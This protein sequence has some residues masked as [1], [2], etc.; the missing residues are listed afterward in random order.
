MIWR[1]SNYMNPIAVVGGAGSRTIGF[2]ICQY[3]IG[4]TID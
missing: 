3:H 1:H 2:T 4:C